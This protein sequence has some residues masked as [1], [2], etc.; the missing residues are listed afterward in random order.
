LRYFPTDNPPY[1]SPQSLV[2]GDL[3]HDGRNDVVVLTGRAAVTGGAKPQLHLLRQKADGTLGAATHLEPPVNVDGYDKHMVG[4]D[5]NHD[6][7]Q[8]LVLSHSWGLVTYLQ[9]STGTLG[10]PAATDTTMNNP[11][12]QRP[13]VLASAAVD[14]DGLVDVIAGTQSSMLDSTTYLDVL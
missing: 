6:G 3:D 5:L 12:G 4:A 9:T 14:G 7:R 1:T 11:I 13:T 10:A 2:I 8:D